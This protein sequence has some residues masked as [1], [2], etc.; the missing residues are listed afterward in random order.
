[1]SHIATGRRHQAPA[2]LTRNVAAWRERGKRSE[3][4]GY[5]I[6][7][8]DREGGSPTL[9]Y[10]HGFPSSSYDWRHVLELEMKQA[11]V[12]FDFLGF[13]LSDKPADHTYSLLWQADLAEAIARRS[14]VGPFFIVAHDMGTSVATELMARDLAGELTID[15]TGALLFNGSILLHLAKPTIAQRLLRGRLGPLLSKMASERVFRNQFGSVFSKDH[16]LST[17]EADDQWC[18]IA[19]NG[20]HRLGHKLVYY[21]SERET[22]TERWHG[23][24]R[25]WQK[26]LFL[27]WGMQDPV[28]RPA[29][30]EGLRELRPRAPVA[31]LHG[32]GH[33]PQLEVP[34][35]LAG[36]I[37]AALEARA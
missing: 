17:E 9:V 29:V 31:E 33:Y 36:E 23:A 7:V 5:S 21:M 37:V 19:H 28:A 8:H 2:P 6:H 35:L 16:P 11:Y 32:V 10:L 3:F 20:G 4:G 13:G 22:L 1:L 27:A 18:L 25:D 24:F 12:A 15:V 30:L 26:P 14:G 34:N